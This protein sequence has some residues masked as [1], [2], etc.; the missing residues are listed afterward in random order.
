MRPLENG[1]YGSPR[2]A[3]GFGTWE[4][5][6]DAWGPN[7]SDDAV[8][9]AIRA[10]LD[11]GMTWL[12]TAETYGGGRAEILAGRATAGRD[13]FVATKVAPRP[14]GSGVRP[15]Q[16]RAACEGSL[17]RLGRDV[18]DL[19]QLHWP[20]ERE[21]PLE[22]T[23]EAM[24]SLVED[25]LVRHIGLSNVTRRHVERCLRIH[26]VASIQ[27]HLSAVAPGERAMAAWAGER[28]IG[29]IAYGA[30]GYGLLTGTISLDSDLGDWRADGGTDF[31]EPLFAPGRL[32]RS[33]RLTR[34]LGRVA[35]DLGVPPARL[36]IAWVLHQPGVSGVVAGTRNPK[37]ASE[38]ARAGDLTLDE[39]VLGVIE[40]LLPLGPAYGDDHPEALFAA[41]TGAVV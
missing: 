10:G 7:R 31:Y 17:R 3:V 30:L 11:A 6:G 16:V 34:E 38:N 27:C 39:E 5:G 29:V 26:P 36:A 9:G 2:S 32:E 22:E 41:A 25:G 13:V 21:A 8:V 19:Y 15:Q 23:W 33:L 18:I 1:S 20:D 35:V 40:D 12:D 24:A 28:G 37:H 4:A 14:A